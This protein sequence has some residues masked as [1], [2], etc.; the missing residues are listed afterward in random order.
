[1]ADK[2]KIDGVPPL[3]KIPSRIYSGYKLAHGGEMLVNAGIAGAEWL[4]EGATEAQY[5]NRAAQNVSA[6]I[7]QFSQVSGALRIRG[8][9]KTAAIKS[10]EQLYSKLNDMQWERNVQG[11]TEL[12]NYGFDII[13]N[14]NGTVNVPET[15]VSIAKDFPQM[16]PKAQSKLIDILGLD[17]NTIELLREGVRLSDLLAKATHFGLTIDPELNAQLTELNKQTTELGV[18]WDGLKG[19]ISNVGY[20]IAVSDGSIANGIGGLTDLLTHGP[21]NFSIMRFFDVINGDESEKMRWAY[22]NDDFKRQLNWY[23]STML[24]SGFMTDGFRKKYQDYHTKNSGQKVYKGIDFFPGFKLPQDELNP[25]T[26]SFNFGGESSS[27]EYIFNESVGDTWSKNRL[28]NS[29]AKEH[30]S[31]R[32]SPSVLSEN[33]MFTAHNDSSTVENVVSHSTD[34]SRSD[35]IISHYAGTLPDSDGITDPIGVLPRD[36][37]P[38]TPMGISP[39]GSIVAGPVMGS[40]IYAESANGDNFN[41]NVIADVIATAMQNNRVQ[42]ELTLID[43]RT[44]ETSVLLGQGGGRITYAMAMP[45]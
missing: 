37:I 13:S 20:K 12:N 38:N 42:I 5:I 24:N 8:A 39:N 35:N 43:G 31:F 36:N 22:N 11:L 18:A 44:G 32:P 16:A 3:S 10:T 4:D 30:Y 26:N 45:M 19:K 41:A 23:E 27:D 2:Y 33:N 17:S 7:E 28:I 6:P 34:T 14:E 1:M 21:D 29:N 25:L 15:M 9:E 40:P